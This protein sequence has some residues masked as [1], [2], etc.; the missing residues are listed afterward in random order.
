[1]IFETTR[2][3]HGVPYSARCY[4]CLQ[5][6]LARAIGEQRHSCHTTY[7]IDGKQCPQPTRQDARM[8][9]GCVYL[10]NAKSQATDAALSRQ[11]ACTD[12]L[13]L[14]PGKD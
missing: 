3:P 6:G 4:A 1:M 5:V 9:G 13:G 12:G 14:V 2:C 7:V 11:V 8:C 10:G